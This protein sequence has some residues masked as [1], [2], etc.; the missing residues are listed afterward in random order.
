MTDFSPSYINSRYWVLGDLR[1]TGTG[2][3]SNEMVTLVDKRK[4]KTHS[5]LYEENIDTTINDLIFFNQNRW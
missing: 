1:T 5:I 4:F 3:I 2:H